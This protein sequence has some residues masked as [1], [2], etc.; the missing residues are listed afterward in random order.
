MDLIDEV[1]IGHAIVVDALNYGFDDT[2]NK[3][4]SATKG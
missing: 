3:Y 4:I 1:S 2:I